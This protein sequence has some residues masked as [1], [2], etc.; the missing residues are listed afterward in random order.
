MALTDVKELVICHVIKGGSNILLIKPDEGINKDKWNAPGGKIDK[1][2]NHAKAAMRHV[3]QQTGLFVN[4]VFYNGT[5]RLFLNGKNEYSYR[6]H[7]YS[8]KLFSGDLKPNIKGEAKWFASADI[9]YYEMW[10]DDKYWLG[11]V[12]QGKEFNADFFFDEKNEKIV[13]YSVKEKER[14]FQK[15]LP[16]IIIA[17]VIAVVVFGVISSGILSSFKSTST[18]PKNT[19]SLT[20]PN[21]VTTI[22]QNALTN[23]LTTATTTIIQV[24][25][26]APPPSTYGG[27]PPN[28]TYIYVS[29]YGSPPSTHVFVSTWTRLT[30][31]PLILR[32]SQCEVFSDYV[33]CTAAPLNNSYIEYSAA[34]ADVSGS[35]GGGGTSSGASG[36]SNGTIRIYNPACG[37]P[38]SPFCY[39][40]YPT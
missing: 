15:F 4:K 23:T 40:V 9:P 8:T 10:A 16:A 33:Y 31:T 37:T 6:M 13:K 2:E 25:P 28:Q 35:D 34:G 21:T 12:L 39:N 5:I 19:V 36:S 3:F 14:V 7:I 1:N 20:P 30:G 29:N 26:P 24:Q 17:A 38:S 22:P 18:I 27:A 32:N 11:L